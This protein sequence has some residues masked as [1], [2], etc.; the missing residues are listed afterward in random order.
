MTEA[1]NAWPTH[2]TLY[3]CGFPFYMLTSAGQAVLQYL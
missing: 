1:A 3:I 2:I